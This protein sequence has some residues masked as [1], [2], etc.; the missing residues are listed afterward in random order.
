MASAA[1]KTERGELAVWRR[2]SARW[3]ERGLR[4][5]ATRFS[6][7]EAFSKAVGLG[8]HLPMHW[9]RCEIG[10]APGGAPCIV[11]HGEL[12][13]WF[14][15]QGLRVHNPQRRERLRGE[16]CVVERLAKHQHAPVAVDGTGHELHRAASLHA[17]HQLSCLDALG[18]QC[19]AAGKQLRAQRR[20]LAQV[21]G[22]GLVP[23][24][25]RAGRRPRRAAA[26]VRWRR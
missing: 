8:M 21:V 24:G 13:T 15:A 20:G 22:D 7:K 17:R 18:V 4:Y 25:W 19:V 26:G 1:Q 6:A 10:N 3:P 23:R 14:E 12:K 11:L 2:R 16:F 9:R 5:L